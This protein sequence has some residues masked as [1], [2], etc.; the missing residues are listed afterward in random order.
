MLRGE[1]SN[2]A[3][4]R[5]GVDYR[6]VLERARRSALGR[7]VDTSLRVSG[8]CGYAYTR[9]AWR[10]GAVGWLQRNLNYCAVGF[11]IGEEDLREV[12]ESILLEHIGEVERFDTRGEF[13]RWVHTEYQLV[14]VYTTD[15]MLIGVDGTVV[16]HTGWEDLSD[17]F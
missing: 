15:P 13:M 7:L 1:L 8:Y 16:M 6:V 17:G 4:P 10:C 3:L 2:R 14:R 9:Y 11:I 12:I 5:F